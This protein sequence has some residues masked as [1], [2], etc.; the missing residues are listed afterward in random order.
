MYFEFPI[1]NGGLPLP[2]L[3]RGRVH[4]LLQLGRNPLKLPGHSHLPVIKLLNLI[5]ELFDPI[6]GQPRIL[7]LQIKQGGNNNFLIEFRIGSD[8]TEGR[9][10]T[11]VDD[12]AQVG[13][14]DRLRPFLLGGS[15]LQ[16]TERIEG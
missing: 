8:V 14:V 16:K 3:L 12:S 11:A 1:P 4:G 13:E 7:K 9:L 2:N 10:E 15:L 5:V 6:C